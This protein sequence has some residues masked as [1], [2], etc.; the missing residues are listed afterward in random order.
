MAT[1]DELLFCVKLEAW[2]N[3]T[4][5]IFHFLQCEMVLG[6]VNRLKRIF[7]AISNEKSCLVSMPFLSTYID[8]RTLIFFPP[9]KTWL[10]NLNFPRASCMQ[11]FAQSRKILSKFSKFSAILKHGW[12]SFVMMASIVRLSSNTSWSRTNQKAR[13]MW[14]IM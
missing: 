3:K 9:A 7:N 13:M 4:F 11:G 10:I 5:H 1:L 8:V 12:K 14:V 6:I 2:R